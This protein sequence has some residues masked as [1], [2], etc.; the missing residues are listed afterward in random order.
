MILSEKIGIPA[1]ASLVIRG[2]LIFLVIV[3]HN[4]FVTVFGYLFFK[5]LTLHVY[6]F[7]LISFF[8][9]AGNNQKIYDF[10]INRF[11]RY[12]WPFFIFYSLYFLLYFISSGGYSLMQTFAAAYNYFL[13]L[14]VGSFELVRNGCGGAFMWF[15]PALFGVSLISKVFFY[16]KKYRMHFF[17]IFC[18][19]YFITPFYLQKIGNLFPFGI[20]LAMYILP[21][22]IVSLFVLNYLRVFFEKNRNASIFVLIAVQIILY[23]ILLLDGEQIEMGALLLPTLFS[24][25]KFFVLIASLCCFSIFIYVASQMV[26]DRFGF[27]A[28]L[29]KHSLGIYLFHQIFLHLFYRLFDYFNFRLDKFEIQVAVAVFS[30]FVVLFLSLVASM[31]VGTNS[32]VKNFFFPK[33]VSSLFFKIQLLK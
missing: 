27:L 3:D 23:N 22:M 24:G 2:V 20:L 8:S 7:F 9:V 26:G 11:V 17:I 14:V 30:T 5:P 6:G 33:D 25:F 12:L 18:I 21:L 19:V 4:S 31:I 13:G 16:Y 15:L 28:L 1:H 10:L 29:G 32:R